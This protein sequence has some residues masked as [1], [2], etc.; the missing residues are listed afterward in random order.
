[1]TVYIDCLQII[2]PELELKTESR[3]KLGSGNNRSKM[4]YYKSWQKDKKQLKLSFISDIGHDKYLIKWPQFGS[5]T[6]ILLEADLQMF[7]KYGYK[8][9][10]Q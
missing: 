5:K 1:M 3:K 6:F 9:L 7:A 4:K 10:S 8:N 2:K